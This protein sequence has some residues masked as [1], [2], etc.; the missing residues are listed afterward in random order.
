LQIPKLCGLLD[1]FTDHLPDSAGSH[2]ITVRKFVAG[3]SLYKV[4]RYDAPLNI[5]TVLP[6][7]HGK[8]R[9]KANT[10]I[11]DCQTNAGETFSRYAAYLTGGNPRYHSRAD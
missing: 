4:E 9:G 10:A 5:R 11:L 6:R 2:S 1:P 3:P 7:K 8:L